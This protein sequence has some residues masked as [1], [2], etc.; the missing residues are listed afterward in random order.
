MTLPSF[1]IVGAMKAGTT[2]LFEDLATHPDVFPP[3]DKEPGN[4]N[5]DAVLSPD[6]RAAY[7]RCF[8]RCPASKVTFEASTYYTMLQEYRGAP[9]RAQSLLGRDL[10]VVYIVREPVARTISHHRHMM[11]SNEIG[12]DIN[13][14]VRDDSRLIGYS[15]YLHQI[16]PWLDVFGQQQ[17]MLVHFESYIADR[18]S[19]VEA[20]Q[21]FLGFQ[22]RG[23][24]VLTGFAANKSQ[25][26]L[27]DTRLSRSLSSSGLYRNLIRPIL[28]SR[29]KN[30]AKQLVARRSTASPTQISPETVDMI[31]EQTSRD[32]SGI[33]SMVYPELE[34][35]TLPWKAEDARARALGDRG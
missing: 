23:D 14:A 10:K 31:L 25:G 30:R 6:G 8:R 4:L 3:E 11:D 5:Q 24:L 15:R 21:A 33:A 13:Q 12:P 9:Q 20:V 16:E 18:V 28:P 7:E 26:K 1:L 32:V 27:V 22:P 34:P 35:G 19:V 29:L 2:T 17:V